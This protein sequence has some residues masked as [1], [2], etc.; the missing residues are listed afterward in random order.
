MKMICVTDSD[1]AIGYQG[2]L[3]FHLSKDMEHFKKLT[4]GHIVVMGRKTRESLPM[5]KPLPGRINIIL[6]RDKAHTAKGF[7]ICHSMQEV[8]LV[9]E[10]IVNQENAETAGKECFVIGGE[11]IYK[12][13][14]EEADTVYR[15]KV[16]AKA[17]NA[18]TWFPN[19]DEK[20]DWMLESESSHY[21]ENGV[22][23]GVSEVLFITL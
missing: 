2:K 20:P 4:M 21:V 23:F 22:E 12:L 5:G 9:I 6:T 15:T 16:F 13:F 8:K 3:L 14:L 11:E 19:L 17:K 1:Q 18:D 7:V 10:E